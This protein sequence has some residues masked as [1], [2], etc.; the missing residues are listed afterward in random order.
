MGRAPTERKAGDRAWYLAGRPFKSPIGLQM[1]LP[2]LLQYRWGQRQ[3]GWSLFGS[4]ASSFLVALWTWGTPQSWGFLALAFVVHVVSITDVL[5][6]SSFPIYPAKRAL[7]IVAA[8]LG[9]VFY[10][11]AVIGLS[12]VAWPGFEPANTGVGFLVNRYA[13]RGTGPSQG[14]WI[15]MHPSVAGEPRAAL[16]VAISGQEVEWNGQSWKIDGQSRPLHSPDRLTAWPQP[17]TFKVPPNQILVE[18]RDDGVSTVSIGP[19]V[20]VSP[21]RII[22]RAWAQFYPV[23]DRRIL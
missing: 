4:F 13:Y 7:A 5:R 19:V 12:L 11:P 17:C 10:L 8:T 18:P 2:G 1:L 14:Q 9:M 15:W 6:Q 23:W 21:D 16:V 22:G 20:L 3:R